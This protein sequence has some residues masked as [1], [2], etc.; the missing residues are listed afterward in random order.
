[1]KRL[2]PK[3]LSLLTTLLFLFGIISE[4]AIAQVA[5]R[6]TVATS[7][8]DYTTITAALAA[9]TPSATDPYVIDVMPG[10]YVES[11]I[12]MKNYVHLRGAGR[13]VTTIQAPSTTDPVIM[14]PAGQNNITV[15]GLA[16][17]NGRFAISVSTST[18]IVVRDNDLR[19]NSYDIYINDGGSVEI[20]GNIISGTGHGVYIASGSATITGNVIAGHTGG[21]GIV[22]NNAL[23]SL[24]ISNNIISQNLFGISILGVASTINNNIITGNKFAGLEIQDSD[25]II[26]NTITG[27]GGVSG[28]AGIRLLSGSPILSNNRITNNTPKDI[29]FDGGTP[30]VSF[31]VYDTLGGF[32]G[33]PP[34]SFNVKS[35][36]TSW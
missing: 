16:I 22:S 19:S 10:T 4:E 14:T 21:T 23:S 30:N 17:K 32:S 8:G 18:S 27:N 5:H 24:N 11:L 2:T 7:G 12:T 9:I 20:T 29:E 13:Q 33:T 35:N 1:M 26:G 34:G 36:G 28:Y 3:T 15:S 6:V 25:T 31:N